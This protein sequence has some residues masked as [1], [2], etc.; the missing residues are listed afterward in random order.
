MHLA[1]VI[2]HATATIKHP[3]LNGWRLVVVQPLG[4]GRKNDGEPFLAIDQL[5]SGKGD[6]VM[7][8]SDG[9]GVREMVGRDDSPIRWAI[10]GVIDPDRHD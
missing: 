5:G 2:G 9:K 7:L 1:Q 4:V 6:L 3:S 10:I 8:T